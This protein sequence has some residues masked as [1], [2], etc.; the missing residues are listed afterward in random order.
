MSSAEMLCFVRYSGVIFGDLIP[1]GNEHW[2]LWCNLIE[3][4]GILSSPT[5]QP[6]TDVLLATL[7]TEHNGLF[8]KLFKE[9][10]K[11]KFHFMLHYPYCMK[12]VGPLC[13]IASLRYESKHQEAKMSANATTSRKDISH[14]LAMK[15]QLNICYRLLAGD[16]LIS[17]FDVGPGETMDSC[18]L[19]LFIYF[20]DALPANFMRSCFVTNWVNVRGTEYKPNMMLKLFQRYNLPVFGYIKYIL[21]DPDMNV[22]FVTLVCQVICFDSH[23]QAYEVDTTNLLEQSE[24]CCILYDDLSNFMPH[25]KVFTSSGKHFVP[26]RFS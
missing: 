19:D 26:V 3:I 14:T 7:V 10:L 11:P 17:R 5:V 20:R 23:F 25:Y 24:F 15:H 1:R 16:G 13:D 6:S 22:C 21:V 2:Q 8:T 4:L 9:P 12:M 18:D